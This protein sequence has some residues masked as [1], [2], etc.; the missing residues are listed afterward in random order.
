MS[1]PTR[2]EGLGKY[3]QQVEGKGTETYQQPEARETEQFLSK[4]WKLREHNKRV[5]DWISNMIIVR[6]RRRTE[7]NNIHK[8][9]Q[10]STIKISNWKT[11]G[12]D[13]THG[14]WFKKFITINNR[15]AL[16]M[17]RCLQERQIPEWMTKE[18]TTLIKKDTLKGT[19]GKQLQTHYMPTYDTENTNSKN[20]GRD[21]FLAN[22]PWIVPWGTERIPQRIKRH[23]RSTLYSSTHPQ[24]KQ[25]LTE[26]S[27]NCL[28][29]QQ[30]RHMI[31]SHKD[32]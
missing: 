27:S 31:W 32:E 19:T 18:K 9:T 15:Q 13:G 5:A 25:D 28:D 1:Y 16:E 6:T 23:G 2:A 7:S 30:K 21:I 8:F 10:N 22:K 14:F 17:N 24:Q 20:K 29:L 11:L 12:H 26:K 4:V 3:D